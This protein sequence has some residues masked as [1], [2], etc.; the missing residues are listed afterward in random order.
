MT[1]LKINYHGTKVEAISQA[2]DNPKA[3]LNQVGAYMVKVT[4]RSFRE[5]KRGPFNWKPRRTPNIPGAL[6]DLENSANVKSR[7]FQDQPVLLDTAQLSKSF[8]WRTAGPRAIMFGTRVPYANIHQHGGVSKIKVT[9]SMREN[10]GVWLK[11]QRGK[12][13]REAAKSGKQAENPMSAA[14]G[15]V[16]Q[17]KAGQSIEFNVIARPFVVFTVEDKKQVRAIIMRSIRSAK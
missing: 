7:R 6:R 8:T 11:R 3:A 17:Y 13:K 12:E 9:K 16:F 14:F 4:Q 1:D 5:H 15:W 10:L 2:L